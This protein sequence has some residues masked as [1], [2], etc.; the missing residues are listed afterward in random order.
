MP[1]K[2]L[3]RWRR[4]GQHKAAVTTARSN[5]RQEV[6]AAAKKLSQRRTLDQRLDDSRARR[7]VKATVTWDG[8]K[9]TVR[10]R[11]TMKPKTGEL[12]PALGLA[13]K[14]GTGKGKHVP[15]KAV[16]LA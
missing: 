2:N 10:G 15:A 1:T 13:P 16:T 4:R 12:V 11:F 7:A 5:A 3:H 6:G 9:W 8:K 14:S